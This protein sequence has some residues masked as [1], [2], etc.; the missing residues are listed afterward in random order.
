MLVKKFNNKKDISQFKKDYSSGNIQTEVISNIL[1][2]YYQDKFPDIKDF[3]DWQFNDNP[4]SRKMMALSFFM[5]SYALNFLKDNFGKCDFTFEGNRVYKNYVFEFEGLTFIT[6]SKR[7]IVM[8]EG[9][10][11]EN[12]IIRLVSF[13]K[14]FKQFLFTELMKLEN[15]LPDFIQKDIDSLKLSGLISQD[16][17]INFDFFKQYKKLKP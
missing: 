8:T 7:E 13:E 10:H 15:Q 6:P 16:N 14:T 17:I 3:M 2:P 9:P 12:Y 4:L 5:E 11:W 1:Q